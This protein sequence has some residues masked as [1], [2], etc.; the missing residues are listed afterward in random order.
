MVDGP[1]EDVTLSSC[2][3]E[4]PGERHDL[5]CG[6][7]GAEMR[8]RKSKH[9]PFYGCSTW[10]T[11][12]GTHGAHPD[13]R[14][15]GIPANKKTRLARMR[16]HAVFDLIW[17]QRVKK[18]HQAYG[19]MRQAMGLTHSQAH[20]ACFSEDQCEQ[21]IQLVYRDFPKFRTRYSQLSYGDDFEDS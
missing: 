21:L 17:K 2:P 11:C 20:I 5:H 12:D 16:A 8:L 7:C 4:F 1:I 3:P 19:W 14:P 6:E 10:P 9:G 18:R 15:K 13:G